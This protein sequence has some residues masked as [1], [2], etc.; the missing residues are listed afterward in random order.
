MK[1]KHYYHIIENS[2]E[3]Y[4]NWRGCYGNFIDAQKALLQIKKYCPDYYYF[5]IHKDSSNKM[6][7]FINTT[8]FNY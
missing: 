2:F 5:F 7:D 6:P 3:T 1:P 4:L 8:E